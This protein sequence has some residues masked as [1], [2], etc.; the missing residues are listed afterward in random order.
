MTNTGKKV[1]AAQRRSTYS[2]SVERTVRSF[3]SYLQVVKA[4]A[5]AVQIT[6]LNADAAKA[7]EAAI[8]AKAAL[9]DV[10]KAAKADPDNTEKADAV[11][12]AKA[13]LQHAEQVRSNFA[14]RIQKA[15][16]VMNTAPERYEQAKET[17]ADV[18]LDRKDICLDFLKQWLP[19]AI[20]SAGQVCDCKKVALED[21]QAAIAAESETGFEHRQQDGILIELRPV[22]L[23]TASKLTAK[24]AAAAKAKAKA[25]S[26][27]AQA[28][29][30][31][32]RAEKERQRYLAN[33]RR[34]REYQQAHGLQTEQPTEQP[35]E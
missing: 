20:N 28:V 18:S 9:K 31:Q 13:A 23:W 21:E 14:D 32:E 6:A 27:E 29:K 8:A 34:V 22:R 7:A 10:E 33:L 24:F 2:K 11:K 4:D 17:L 15:A 12:A 16:D 25:A 35:A 3:N 19:G 1:T 30:E 26:A 5:D